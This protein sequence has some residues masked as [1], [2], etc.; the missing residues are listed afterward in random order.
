MVGAQGGMLN[1]LRAVQYGAP[2]CLWVGATLP[3]SDRR[4][5][6]G[7][8][9]IPQSSGCWRPPHSHP[10]KLW[11]PGHMCWVPGDHFT[12][13]H[14]DA[15]GAVLKPSTGN[16]VL[17]QIPAGDSRESSREQVVPDD[18]ALFLYELPSLR[19]GDHT[20]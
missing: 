2:A 11:S 7:L 4:P 18:G 13:V 1:N 17:N 5:P 10:L 15:G 3:M 8:V 12:L 6:A 20:L 16:R 14:C 19:A 9:G